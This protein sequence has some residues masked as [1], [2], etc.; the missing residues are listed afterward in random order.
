[1]FPIAAQSANCPNGRPN[2][3]CRNTSPPQ[4]VPR[5]PGAS[6]TAR[7]QQYQRPSTPALPPQHQRPP[8]PALPPQQHQRPPV[9]VPPQHVPESPRFSPPRSVETRVPQQVPQRAAHQTITPQTERHRLQPSDQQH[10]V[11]LS[12]TATMVPKPGHAGFTATKRESAHGSIIVEQRVNAQGRSHVN[13]YRQIVSADGHATTR[14]YTDGRRSIDA[15]DFHSSG[16]VSGPQIVQYHNGLR[17]AYTQNGRPLYAETFTR[18][19]AQGADERSRAGSI[20]QR[21][22]YAVTD[23]GH[24]REL[25]RPV[26]RFYVV[27][28]F[29][30][31]DTFVY[32]P[33]VYP[34]PLYALFYAPLALPLVVGPRCL[35]CPN[36]GAVFEV[37]RSQ[38]SDPIDLLGDMQIAEAVNDQGVAPMDEQAADPTAPPMAGDGTA[39]PPDQPL[40]QPDLPSEPMPSPLASPP[41]AP[42]PPPEL[43]AAAA[44]GD[45]S[46]DLDTLKQQADEL[47]AQGA[48]RAKQ[49]PSIAGTG[50]DQTPTIV[51][52]A[53]VVTGQEKP[54][55]TLAVTEDVRTQIHKQVRLSLAQHAREHPLTLIDIMQSGFS[56][57]YLFQV[58]GAIDTASVITGDGCALGSGDLLAFTSLGDSQQ[59]PTAQMRVVATRPGHCLSHDTVE[60]SVGDLQDMLNTFNQRLEENMRKLHACVD[61]KDGC[62]R[63]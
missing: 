58:A 12:T 40:A 27:T 54:T 32:R 19:R 56:R 25:S 43:T 9:P 39:A 44:P 1:M 38:Y 4:P 50:D 8:T 41:P 20:V 48:A 31:R 61:A 33:M 5:T 46:N 28:R 63:T 24:I 3:P 49:D 7:P 21:T 14:I 11:R 16:Q 60:V 55:D 18:N 51:P 37:P 62:V 23:S 30:E 26:R 53:A 35:V 13:A 52:V 59:R 57:I 15:A 36:V 17:A 29:G 2:T 47:Q 6:T 34:A 10:R 42:P 22:T 45:D